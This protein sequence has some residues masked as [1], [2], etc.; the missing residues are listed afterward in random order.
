MQILKGI[1]VSKWQGRN[2]DFVGAKNAGYEFAI[3]RI[4]ASKTKDIYFE[5]NYVSA[6]K[7]GLKVAVY[8]YT[9][10]TTD[11]QGVQDATR[12]LG[13]LNNR[14]VF[15]V[16]YDIEDAKQK[17]VARKTA[18]ATM[19][20]AFANKIKSK[21]YDTMLYTGEYFFNHYFDKNLITDP[22]W[23]A[24]YSS[25][26]PS[27]GRVLNIWQ[28]TSDAFPNDFYTKKLDRNYLLNDVWGISD[29][30]EV[31]KEVATNPYAEPTRTIKRTYPTM[32]GNDVRWCQWELIQSGFLPALNAKGNSNIDGSFGDASKNATIAYQKA[33][34]LLVDG[35]IGPATRYSM[36]NDVKKDNNS[37]IK[38]YLK[39]KDGETKLSANF[40]VKEFACKDGSEKI[41]ISAELVEV[42]QK[43]RTHF[44]K[45]VNINSAYR[46]EAYNK[47]V[48]GVANSQHLYGTAADIVVSGVKASDVANYAETL[49]PNSG[50][51]GR[52]SNFTHVDVR[53]I[54]SRW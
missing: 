26:Q 23:I 36:K 50:G 39:A 34:G 37:M 42:L 1:D 25:T 15:C 46:T 53:G 22:L 18:N 4:G 33:Y 16:A 44:G 49:L 5:E 43:I 38:E 6:L 41:L 29:S 12:V 10:S 13:W 40:K 24:K 52:Y 8:Y 2:F 17:S 11:E 3:I 14:P 27:V 47:K 28:Y 45:P 20:N 51:I 32:K 7:A 9:Y 21:G 19:Y 48:G 30:V 31:K 54:K 35:K